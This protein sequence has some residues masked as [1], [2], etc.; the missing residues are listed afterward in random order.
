MWTFLGRRGERSS[1]AGQE[2]HLSAHGSGIAAAGNVHFSG[3]LVLNRGVPTGV[4][5]VGS[6]AVAFFALRLTTSVA[7]LSRAQAEDF[8]GGALIV[9]SLQNGSALLAFREGG[10]VR[11]L[12]DGDGGVAAS[13]GQW[14]IDDR[15]DL[16]IAWPDGGPSELAG[17]SRLAR[18]I[19]GTRL[20]PEGSSEVEL[21]VVNRGNG[22]A[23]NE[24][25]RESPVAAL[26]KK[27]NSDWPVRYESPTSNYSESPY[28]V[29]HSLGSVGVTS[30][31]STLPSPPALLEESMYPVT[32]RTSTEQGQSFEMFPIH[33]GEGV[34]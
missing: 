19:G 21:D 29:L 6:L 25:K 13:I 14:H 5:V 28:P 22:S 15:G 1:A 17:C 3:N 24:L 26:P 34:R 10:T 31:G 12:P 32:K 20:V 2:R 11:I 27:P 9:A 30:R 18:S 33:P 23:S 8:V 16:C 7:D 4:V